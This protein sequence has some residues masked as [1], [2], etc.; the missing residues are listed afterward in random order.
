MIK[1]IIIAQQINR[2]T[3][4]VTNSGTNIEV[5]TPA[6]IAALFVIVSV[7]FPLN[8]LNTIP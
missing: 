2:S 8:A 5:I 1:M 3:P 4:I 7:K 6:S